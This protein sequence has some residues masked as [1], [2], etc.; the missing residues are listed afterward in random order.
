VDDPLVMTIDL[1]S[2]ATKAALWSTEG[3]VAIGRAPLM[4]RTPRPE[5]AE[6]DPAAWWTSSVAACK[7]LPAKDRRRVAVVGF[8]TQR[9]ALVPVAASGEPIGAAIARG[10]RRAVE[11]AD[12]LGDEF[13]VLT[14][15]V[16]DPACTAA[17]VAWLREHEPERLDAARWIL[18]PRDLVVL[19]LTGRAVTDPS[20]TSRTGLI[21]IDGARLEGGDLLPDV[22]ASTAVIGASLEEPSGSL[23]IAPGTPVVVGAG[24][25][26]CEI[27]G[28][29][30]SLARPMVSWGT[31]AGVSI[32]VP[33][34][35]PPSKGVLVTR[36][37][38]GGYVME[39]G[40]SSGGAALAWVAELSQANSVA[41]AAEAERIAPGAE[42]L[43]ALPWLSGARAPWWESRLGM[44]FTG[45]A[46]HHAA[47]HLARA[48]VEGM[49]FDA[50]RCLERS[51]PD[52]V[53][54][55]LAGGG[56]A[57]PLWRRVLSGVTSR[58]VVSY[59]HGEAASVGAALLAGR[60]AGI[61]LERDD[62]D[63]VERREDPPDDEVLA[64]A[65]LRMRHD[66]VA[67]ATVEALS[68]LR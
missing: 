45:L 54:L 37:A 61:E 32:P 59:R 15:V 38:I 46:P 26:A 67:R 27:L 49:A 31:T 4:T 8:S 2:S 42:G 25:R 30:A 14:G 50:A 66:M 36:G 1:G 10:D 63:P 13:E 57:M 41:L 28:V 22:E 29:A 40:L 23:G 47:P 20:V 12:R 58:P 11:Q 33:H 24:D 35:P 6:Q 62:L 7:R 17:R 39:A 55:A 16:P 19:R 21:A 53:E 5:Q 68:G 64:Y 51:A 44:A 52:A 56:A 48:I 65:E 9:E 18:A 60:A 34:V 3:L 43:I